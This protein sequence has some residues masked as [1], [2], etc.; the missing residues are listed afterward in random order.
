MII[1]ASKKEEQDVYQLI[2]TLE[3]EAFDK[4]TFSKIYQ[5]NITNNLYYVYK[6]NGKCVGFISLHIKQT[7]HH[8]GK[9]GEIIELVVDEA[10]RSQH[11][12]EQL[13][14][15]VETVAKELQLL[16]IEL[17]TNVKR[18]RAHSF[19]KRQGYINNHYNFI[20]KL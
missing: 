8:N 19:Y 7:L 3:Q 12:G 4:K 20:K 18:T 6:S 9:T 10:Y 15:Y 5:E 11:I 13:L 1:R 16:E 2:C 17:S 14:Q